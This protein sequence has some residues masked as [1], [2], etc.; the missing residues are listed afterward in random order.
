MAFMLEQTK[1][2]ISRMKAAGFK[3]NE[4]S[5]KTRRNKY[6]EYGYAEITLHGKMEKY[7]DRIPAMIET[8]ALNVTAFY[9][10]GVFKYMLVKS[11][12]GKLRRIEIG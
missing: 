8:G 3:R 9:H 7:E 6:G 11:G 10:N 4:F 2:A 5:V 1:N 12:T